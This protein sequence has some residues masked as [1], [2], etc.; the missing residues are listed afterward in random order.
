MPS[1]VT[2]LAVGRWPATEKLAELVSPPPMAITP[3]A[4]VATASGWLS[5]P[6][7]VPTMISVVAPTWPE[8][9]RGTVTARQASVASGARR[10]GAGVMLW[11][12]ADREACLGR[13]PG[14]HRDRQRVRALDRA[15]GGHAAQR[16]GVAAGGNPCR[17]DAGVSADGARL[18]GLQ[19]H[20]VAG[21]EVRPGG[22]RR[23]RETARRRDAADREGGSGAA[24]GG[25]RDGLRVGTGD[26]AIGGHAADRHGVVAG[27]PSRLMV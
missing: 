15:I 2:L 16:H 1:S 3:G 12:A 23:D 18:A 21:G 26:G 24:A 27:P 17:G 19:R 10:Q 8:A 20:R 25:Y 22:R 9:V 14:R 7:T 6:V 5:G 11:P 13:G 4:S